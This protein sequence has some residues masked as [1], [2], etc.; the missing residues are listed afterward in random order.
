MGGFSKRRD[1]A[2]WAGFRG[3]PGKSFRTKLR[4]VGPQ[5]SV[6]LLLDME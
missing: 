5:T 6:V 3:A 4:H 1:S 2:C